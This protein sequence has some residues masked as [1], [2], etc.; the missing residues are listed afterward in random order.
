[1]IGI[2]QSYQLKW[3]CLNILQFVPLDILKQNQLAKSSPKQFWS[4]VRNK[5]KAVPVMHI[6]PT[7]FY[8]FY[9]TIGFAFI[10]PI[11]LPENFHPTVSVLRILPLVANIFLVCIMSSNLIFHNC[12]INTFSNLWRLKRFVFSLRYKT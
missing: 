12:R 5:S 6:T 2:F 9:M 7:Q 1:M 10:Q 11:G 3:V 8:S 4:K